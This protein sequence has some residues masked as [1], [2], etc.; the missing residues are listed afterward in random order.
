MRVKV[1][2]ENETAKAARGLLSKAGFAVEGLITAKPGDPIAGYTVYIEETAETDHIMLDS[3][4]CPLENNIL[5]H[6]TELTSKPVTIDRA[7][8]H[9]HSDQEIHIHLPI[10]NEESSRAVE[11]GVMRG[12]LE[13]I[14]VP[15]VAAPVDKTGEAIET[16]HFTEAKISGL[17]RMI[18]RVEQESAAREG[19]IEATVKGF[20][21]HSAEW[22]GRFSGL[23]VLLDGCAAISQDLS[24]RVLGC[25][26]AIGKMLE[27]K[28]WYKRLFGLS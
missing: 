18:S 23:H 28:P 9:V 17:E 10:G 4:D 24:S 1:I 11:F 21:D 27:S 22:E 2:G 5:H 6:I 14:K 16:Q 19:S 20:L 7:G 3:I 8:G 25:E 26:Q 12:L 13:S 15:Q